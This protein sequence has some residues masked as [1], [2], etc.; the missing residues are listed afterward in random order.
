[1][2]DSILRAAIGAEID[3]TAVPPFDL[4]AIRARVT[5]PRRGLTGGRRRW[6]LPALLLL[7]PA[8]A[9]AATLIKPVR[10]HELPN[11]IVQMS[12]ESGKWNLHPTPQ[13]LADF[14]SRAH[15]HAVLPAGLPR[16][17]RLKLIASFGTEVIFINYT[18]ESRRQDVGFLITPVNQPSVKLLARFPFL[19][20]KGPRSSQHTWTIGPERVVIASNSLSVAQISRIHHEMIKTGE[21]TQT[22]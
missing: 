15:F 21:Q 19:Q 22:Q 18:L 8:L 9:I 6:V 10:L 7:V 12:F 11:G 17:A 2:N 4:P 3:G 1:M 5:S 13:D 14:I 20:P 16:S